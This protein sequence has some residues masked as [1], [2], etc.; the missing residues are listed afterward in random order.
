M[1]KG[2]LLVVMLWKNGM[3]LALSDGMVDVEATVV[4]R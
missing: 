2:N 4:T 1:Q 3:P